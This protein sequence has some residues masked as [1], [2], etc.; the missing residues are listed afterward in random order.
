MTRARAR[1]SALRV[2]T[3]I[4]ALKTSV[5]PFD[6]GL[7]KLKEAQLPEGRRTLEGEGLLQ[8][9]SEHSQASWSDSRNGWRTT[10]RS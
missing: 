6:G 10:A 3:K 8:S 2:V 1:K 5:L 4:G 9:V 7:V